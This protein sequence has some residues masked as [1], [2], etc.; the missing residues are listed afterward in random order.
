[1]NTWTAANAKRH[2]SEVLEGALTEPQVVLLRGKPTGVLISVD[3]FAAVQKIQG[4]KT[5]KAWLESLQSIGDEA[6]PE[7]SLRSNRKDQLEGLE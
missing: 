1:M 6:D 4:Q 5:I 7:P 2:F 3:H